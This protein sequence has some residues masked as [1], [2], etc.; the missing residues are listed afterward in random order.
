M[1]RVKRKEQ[2]SVLIGGRRYKILVRKIKDAF[3]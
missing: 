1:P 3:K 2:K